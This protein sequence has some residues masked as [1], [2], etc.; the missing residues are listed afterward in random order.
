MI[1][2]TPFHGL[3]LAFLLISSVHAAPS[4]ERLARQGADGVAACA[5]CHGAQG[6]GN[7]AGSPALAGQPVWQQRLPKSIEVDIELDNGERLHRY[8]RTVLNPWAS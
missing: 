5:S 3:V 6:Q 1:R 4:A 8:F 2:T 7:A